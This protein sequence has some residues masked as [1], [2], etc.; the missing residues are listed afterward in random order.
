MKELS[1]A[2]LSLLLLITGVLNGS[3]AKTPSIN[4]LDK[5]V[6]TEQIILSGVKNIYT[7]A[8]TSLR[9]L[10][11]GIELAMKSSNDKALG[12][13]ML[14][15]ATLF[16]SILDRPDEALLLLR[17][18]MPL[19]KNLECGH[20]EA[21]VDWLMS[22][23]FKQNASTV[24]SAIIYLQRAESLNAENNA[25][26]DNWSIYYSLF[27][28]YYQQ[29]PNEELCD[30]YLQKA[31]DLTRKKGNRMDY[32]YM[33][34]NAII[35]FRDTG[36]SQK[37]ADHYQ[38]YIVNF[39]KKKKW[40]SVEEEF[41]HKD[42]LFGNDTSD[43]QLEK[44]LHSYIKY[45]KNSNN[46]ESLIQT[47]GRMSLAAMRQNELDRAREHAINGRK[48]VLGSPV[49]RVKFTGIL[50]DIESASGD[51]KSAF[52]YAMEEMGL[53]D[54]LLF[55][56]NAE[57]VQDLEVKYETEKKDKQLTAV[58][59]EKEMESLKLKASERKN[60]IAFLII[61]L[62]G[63]LAAWIYHA[64]NKKR[65]VNRELARKNDI[66]TKALNENKLL[67][68][69]IHHRVKN[70]LQVISSLLY[71]QGEYVDDTM[72]AKA[73]Q[74]GQNR[75]KSMALIHKNLYQE[76]NLKGINMKD[77]FDKLIEGLFVSYKIPEH[78]IQL[79]K[80]VQAISL[81]VDTV[82]PLALIVNELISNSLEHAFQKGEE[83][84]L[85]V[86]LKEEGEILRVGVQDNGVGMPLDID[87][88]KSE[89]FGFEM[90]R[91]FAQKLDAKV[92]VQNDNG[93]AIELKI[94]N[95]KR[96]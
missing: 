56:D 93:C 84:K 44:R 30:S 69:E 47:Y 88:A 63:L 20:F 28:V 55:A 45:H 4:C 14:E 48:L 74:E 60:I 9:L 22:R 77:Y 68:K 79:T 57:K 41:S 42:F 87:I 25:A 34:Y 36:K 43:F 23:I 38:E 15:K 75:V 62:L 51:Y 59:A 80:D 73:L 82:I 40:K 49:N 37:F 58:R 26:Y 10:N 92:H 8:D 85:G 19:V 32:G 67:L 13:A 21:H 52:R 76:D 54:S 96:A 81:D 11:K 90:I 70:N 33:L 83:G 65:Q 5:S 46:L 94:K 72:A 61:G 2:Y 6:E 29:V 31:L 24:D 71:L 16:I 27:E 86:Y 64:W 53:K 89:S 12:I 17:Q 35:Y 50:R 7:N 3:L 95:Y 91:L 66:I 78:G 1:R 18:S 39:D